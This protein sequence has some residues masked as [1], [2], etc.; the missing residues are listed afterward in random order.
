[1]V[2]NPTKASTTL[3]DVV[4]IQYFTPIGAEQEITY[5]MEC[6]PID[7][8]RSETPRARSRAKPG[9]F[10]AAPDTHKHG[11]IRG[12]KARFGR[13][14]ATKEIESVGATGRSPHTLGV[15]TEGIR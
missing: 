6:P 3:G 13:S 2:I 15:R 7:E 14:A 10:D 9:N 8:E 1:M 5:I 12:C 11:I 4:A